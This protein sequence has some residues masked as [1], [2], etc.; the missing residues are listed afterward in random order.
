MEIEAN[1][2]TFDCRT[3]G[4]GETVLCLHGF[5][6]DPST[7]NAL[8]AELDGYR[9]V[10]PYMRGYGPT[11]AAPDG[12]YSPRALGADAVALGEAL[13][14]RLL[15]GHDWGAVASYA[16]LGRNHPFD[17]V[18]TMAV[19]PRFDALLFSHPRQFIRSWYIWLFQLSG[20]AEA[21][22]R[23]DDFALVELLWSLWSPG[24]D[25]PD[26]RIAS[27]K[28]T[29]ATG[30][31]V[32]H[33]LAA[34]RSMLR[35]SATGLAHRGIPDI[36]PAEPF[37]TPALVLVGADDGCIGPEL[38]DR[39]GESFERARVGRVRDAGHFLHCERPD[40]VAGELR[41]F[42]D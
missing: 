13:D 5:P 26:E 21:L 15:V 18:A 23:R 10:A 19:P 28:K 2:L 6:D 9:L 17:R 12:D 39:A 38:F 32:E 29:F 11:G 14:A 35:A 3:W 1:G 27:V 8:A 34:Y 7:F 24:W 40:V 16:A 41:R 25:W 42:F 20:V 31:T 22:L 33:A 37:E 30:E 36:A 4:D